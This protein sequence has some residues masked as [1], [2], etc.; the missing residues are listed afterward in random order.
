[1]GAVSHH[2]VDTYFY[3]GAPEKKVLIFAHH[4]AVLDHIAIQLAKSVCLMEI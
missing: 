2:I 3:D 4:L 1:M